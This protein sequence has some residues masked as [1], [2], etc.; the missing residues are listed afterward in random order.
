MIM[1]PSVPY[2]YDLSP[3]DL[4]QTPDRPEMPDPGAFVEACGLCRLD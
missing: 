1:P 3:I 4:T 2:A